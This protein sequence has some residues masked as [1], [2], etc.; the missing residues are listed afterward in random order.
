MNN[1]HL[2]IKHRDTSIIRRAW[3]SVSYR[4]GNA[5]LIAA[6]IPAAGAVAR[7]AV[8]GVGGCKDIIVSKATKKI[9]IWISAI[10]FPK[11][12]VASGNEI[13]E[14]ICQSEIYIPCQIMRF[15]V[16]NNRHNTSA[17]KSYPSNFDK[18][19]RIAINLFFGNFLQFK[20]SVIDGIRFP[21]LFIVKKP[22]IPKQRKNRINKYRFVRV[23]QITENR[24]ANQETT[25][26]ALISVEFWANKFN[27]FFR[28]SLCFLGHHQDPFTSHST[29]KPGEFLML[30]DI[31]KKLIFLFSIPYQQRKCQC[32]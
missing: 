16:G 24:K 6:M 2:A 31:A 26:E 7:T 27:L 29:R 25:E 4:I 8:R 21:N 1:S 32:Y 11:F 10:F 3:V 12:I 22:P 5:H 19:I 17:N 23:T 20:K 18:H 15:N 14:K 9:G 13:Y 30:F 28:N